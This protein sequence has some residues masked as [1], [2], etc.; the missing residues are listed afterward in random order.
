MCIRQQSK[1]IFIGN[2]VVVRICISVKMVEKEPKHAIVIRRNSLHL[3]RH[4]KADDA[5]Y[6]DFDRVLIIS[7][8]VAFQNNDVTSY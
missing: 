7:L 6:C 3:R 8:L 5:K 2:L 4:S 1:T